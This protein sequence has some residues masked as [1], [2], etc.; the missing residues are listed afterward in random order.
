M[1]KVLEAYMGEAVWPAE[2]SGAYLVTMLWVVIVLLGQYE[3]ELKS[4]LP[5]M[6]VHV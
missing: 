2:P 6:E 1:H 3:D 5:S 4:G